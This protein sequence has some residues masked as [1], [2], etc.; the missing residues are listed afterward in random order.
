MGLTVVDIPLA[1]VVALA[2]VLGLTVVLDFV[3]VDI[4]VSFA[5]V[6]GV[7]VDFLVAVFSPFEPE[8]SFFWMALY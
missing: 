4:A 6:T 3:F 8:N 1:G 5:I 7:S 2:V